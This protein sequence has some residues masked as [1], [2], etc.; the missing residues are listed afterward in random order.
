MAD[1]DLVQYFI[2]ETNVKFSKLE[3]KIDILIE[4]KWKREGKAILLS[5]AASVVLTIAINIAAIYFQ[6]K[7]K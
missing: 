5:A 7:T 6:Y 3:K 1:K 2:Q 4:D